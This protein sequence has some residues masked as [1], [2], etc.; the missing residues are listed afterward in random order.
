MTR[1]LHGPRLKEELLAQ[2]VLF[3]QESALAV[4][5]EEA[6]L[7]AKLYAQVRRPHGREIDLAI[8]ACALL[9]DAVHSR[10]R[11]TG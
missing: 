2:E 6:A 4:G 11:L 3:P 1:G 5:P 10:R 7:A 8:A 9:R